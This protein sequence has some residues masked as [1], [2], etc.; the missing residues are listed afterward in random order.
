MPK[1]KET[2]KEASKN[3]VEDKEIVKKEVCEIFDVEKNG[4][5]KTIKSCGIEEEKAPSEKQIKKEYKVFKT[6]IIIMMGFVLMFLA[7]IFLINYFNHISVGGVIFEVDKTAMTGKILYRTSLPVS[8]KNGA[9]GRVISTEYNFYLRTNPRTLDKISFN[10][11]VLA[12]KDMV[13]NMEKDFNCEGYGIIGVAN[14]QKLYNFIG[15]KVIRDE[16]AGCDPA[17][18]Y[19]LVNIKE[20]NETKV[21][22]FGPVCYNI[23]IKDC[24]ILEGTEKFMLETFIR[25]NEKM[26]KN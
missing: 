4:E 23:Y 6:I 9:T 21:E 2:K 17:G 12:K 15:T 20:G 7:V 26:N 1:K 14:L 13:L 22:Q 3:P 10:G 24:E 19:M 25:L 16:N 8:Y 11:R 5:E 18:R